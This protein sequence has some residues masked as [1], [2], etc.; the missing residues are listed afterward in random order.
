MTKIF[1]TRAGKGGR[2]VLDGIDLDVGEGMLGLLGANGAGKTTLMRLLTTVLTPTSG[3]IVV[4]GHDLATGP[5][6]RAVKQLLGYLPQELS[7]YPDLTGWEFLDYVALLKGIGDKVTRRRQVGDLL[8]RVSLSEVAKERIAT[9]SGGM[10]RRIGIAQALLGDP[11]LLIVDEPTAG[12][13]PHERMRFRSLLASLGGRRVVILSTH[14][15]DD[16]AQSCPQVA[17]LSA[18]RVAYHGATVGLTS[19]ATGHTYLIPPGHDVP[20]D[21]TVVNA[22]TTPAGT[23]YRVVS[24]RAVTGGKPVE[25]T[26]EDGYAAL[27]HRSGTEPVAKGNHGGSVVIS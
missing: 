27:L 11:R 12:L 22:V 20:E 17:V 23:E 26:L 18:G 9:Y 15:L 24:P 10:K 8:E 3:R 14:I 21:A 19:A 4:D 25:P 7:L 5:G 13:D 2:R 16:V 6:V 1:K